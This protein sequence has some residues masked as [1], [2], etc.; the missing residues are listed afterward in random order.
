MA[1]KEESTNM[2]ERFAEFKELKH[3]DKTTMIS[4][5]EES[6]RNVLAKMFGTDENLD[7]IMNPDKGDVQIF[8]NL[9][10][11][12]DGEVQNPYTQISLSDARADS[13]PDVEIGEEHT[14]EIIFE[15]FGRRAILNLRQ[16]LQSKILDLQKEAIFAQFKGREGELV[17]G[18]VYQTWSKE[19][20]LLDSEDNELL[21]P[22]PEAIPGDFF[23]KGENVRAVIKTVENK[24][25]NIRIIVSRTSEDFLRRLFELEV[26]EIH[27]GLISIRAVARI[28]G[29]RAKIAVESYDDH[30]DPVGACVG[31]K[32]SR[33]HGIVRE[34]RNENIDV[35]PFTKNTE[36]FIQRALSPAKISSMRLNEEEKRAEVFLRPEEVPLAIGKNALNIKLASKLTGYVIDV[37]RDNGEDF[38]DDIYLDEFKDE[39]DAWIIDALKSIGCVTAKN[40]LAMDRQSIIDKADLEEDTVDNLLSILKAEFED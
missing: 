27:D 7:V 26:P 33:I 14:R 1:K 10:V 32:G 28:P 19:T 11:V 16:T 37:Y 18:E 25:N 30:I 34:L 12:P 3:I 39:I 36:L 40:V 22:R 2:V 20:L 5:L 29:E 21:L 35:I 6:F 23:R 8:Q 4:V 9:E 13:N 31:V 24:N 17:N 15:K 38:N